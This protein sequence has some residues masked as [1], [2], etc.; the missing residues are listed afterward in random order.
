MSI[1]NIP[2]KCIHI[3]TLSKNGL[4][5]T[6]IGVRFYYFVPNLYSLS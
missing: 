5:P 6:E 1:L 2:I 3:Q 4:Q